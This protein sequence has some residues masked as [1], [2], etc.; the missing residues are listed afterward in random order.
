[1]AA[2]FQ[3]AGFSAS[4]KLAATFCSTL[5]GTE[6]LTSVVTLIMLAFL[7]VRV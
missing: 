2:G 1:V 5:K 4:W 6:S 3:P 7:D